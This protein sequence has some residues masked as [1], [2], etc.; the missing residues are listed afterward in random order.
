MYDEFCPQN[1]MGIYLVSVALQF[2][3]IAAM[4]WKRPFCLTCFSVNLTLC[5][6][7]PCDSSLHKRN[8]LP[9][10]NQHPAGDQTGCNVF[11]SRDLGATRA[12]PAL[13]AH[14]VWMLNVKRQNLSVPLHSWLPLSQLYKLHFLSY[15]HRGHSSGS[16]VTTTRRVW[17]GEPQ[18]KCFC[19]KTT[20]MVKSHMSCTVL[21]V[22]PL[23]SYSTFLGVVM[24][25]LE[26]KKPHKP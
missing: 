5:P 12:Y 3:K 13:C 11:N 2:W 7:V 23:T 9:L 4:H 16:P 15:V 25:L 6:P 26:G 17:T 10:Q 24:D 19:L 20:L 18:H 8:W 21:V 22:R 14:T 1:R